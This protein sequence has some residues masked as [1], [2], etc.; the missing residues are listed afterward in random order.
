VPV[1]SASVLG[2]A[3]V[4]L[5]EDASPVLADGDVAVSPLP[6]AASSPAASRRDG[7]TAAR[8]VTR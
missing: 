1:S 7:Q 6:Q 8:R 3:A 4:L 5:G 2:A